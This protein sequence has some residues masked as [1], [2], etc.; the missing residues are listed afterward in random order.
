MGKKGKTKARKSKA[1]QKEEKGSAEEQIEGEELKT[2]EEEEIPCALLTTLFAHMIDNDLIEILEAELFANRLCWS[3]RKQLTNRFFA[4]VERQQP[5]LHSFLPQQL[6]GARPEFLVALMYASHDSSFGDTHAAE[7]ITNVV[8]L[9]YFL[10]EAFEFYYFLPS[11]AL[12]YYNKAI[13]LWMK[14]KNELVDAETGE[15]IYHLGGNNSG[16]YYSR[17]ISAHR[18]ITISGSDLIATLGYRRYCDV[19]LGVVGSR[20]YLFRIQQGLDRGTKRGRSVYDPGDWIV[21]E[22][23]KSSRWF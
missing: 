22:S 8:S 4:M 3:M 14:N 21:I 18:R 11:T 7:Q 2:V 15:L 23:K 19:I 13:T 17:P 10:R 5:V 20:V 9:Y 1:K 16:Y 6:F 12:R